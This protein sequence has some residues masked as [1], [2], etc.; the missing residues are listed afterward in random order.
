MQVKIRPTFPLSSHPATPPLHVQRQLSRQLEK[1]TEGDHH[2]VNFASISRHR[3]VCGMRSGMCVFAVVQMQIWWQLQ[4]TWP[5]QGEIV[6]C[7]L[8]SLK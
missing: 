6:T 7:W 2:L 8:L 1:V 5:N 4:E 3:E